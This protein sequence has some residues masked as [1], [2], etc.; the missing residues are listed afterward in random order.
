MN[1]RWICKPLPHEWHLPLNLI[2]LLE[3]AINFPVSVEI[4]LSTNP[5]TEYPYGS[6]GFFPISNFWRDFLNCFLSNAVLLLVL[7]ALGHSIHWDVFLT[8]LW[9]VFL[10][11]AA[12][13]CVP[14]LTEKFKDSNN[15]VGSLRTSGL[16]SCRLQPILLT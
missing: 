6:L 3:L 10:G 5:V 14:P 4:D 9:L 1:M 12:D 16:D 13:F 11:V 7:F 2:T 8:I 15:F